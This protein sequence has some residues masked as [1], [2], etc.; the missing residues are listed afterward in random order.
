MNT[1]FKVQN[2]DKS[3]ADQIKS[4]IDE[5]SKSEASPKQLTLELD[6]TTGELILAVEIVRMAHELKVEL[7]TKA[8]GKLSSAGT[9]IAGAG[10]IGRR[11]AGLQTLLVL[12]DAESE[13]LGKFRKVANPNLGIMEYMLVRTTTKKRGVKQ[14]LASMNV[15]TSFEAVEL[16]IL[17]TL[18]GFE[19]MYAEELKPKSKKTTGAATIQIE[20]EVT[21]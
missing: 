10:K 5:I 6:S 3:M 19:S 18:E 15:I 7:L 9:V 17:D 21:K 4:S 1:S 13:K 12:N 20:S 2:L 11:S 14:A 16:G 8:S